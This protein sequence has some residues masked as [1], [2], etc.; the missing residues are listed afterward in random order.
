MRAAVPAF[1]FESFNVLR[2]NG[3]SY[4]MTSSRSDHSTASIALPRPSSRFAPSRRL[5]LVSCPP[6][7]SVT[8]VRTWRSMPSKLLRSL[9]FVTPPSASAPYTAEP[10]PVMISTLSIAAAGIAFV[11][12]TSVECTGGPRRPAPTPRG[13]CAPRPPRF[14][15][16]A[17]G[18]L[19]AL[20][21]RG[22]DRVRVDHERRVHRLAAPAVDEHEGSLR[23][24][25]AQVHRGDAGRVRRAREDVGRVELGLSGHELRQLVQDALDR[26]RARLL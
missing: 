8:P 17:P 16:E 12:I 14:T 1:V 2:M 19:A 13:R 3:R 23:P 5:T 21:R 18:E 4:A 9:K 22:G 11:S 7:C 20:G 25:P 15:V 10:P 26:E 24:E 6:P